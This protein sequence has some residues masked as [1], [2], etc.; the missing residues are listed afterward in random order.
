MKTQTA[1]ARAVDSE[2]ILRVVELPV[3][4]V[5]EVKMSAEKAICL[6]EE[7]IRAARIVLEEGGS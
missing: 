1:H 7:L 5:T 4:R 2:V 3:V 6:A